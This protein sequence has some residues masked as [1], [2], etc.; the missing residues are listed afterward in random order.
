MVLLIA[1]AACGNA[2]A[3]ETAAACPPLREFADAFDRAQVEQDRPALEW[4]VSD[5]L[6]YI[7]GTGNR[8]GKRDFI[9]GW[10]SP[11]DD[12]EMPTLEDR[13]VLEL[14]P[15]A[16]IANARALLKGTSGGVPFQSEIRF[17]DAFR[18][19]SGCWRAIHIQVTRIAPKP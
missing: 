6:V 5:A 19:E 2:I 4:M 3:A 8:H 13:V 11:G 7:D 17:A 14:G 10:M 18:K 16:G 1:S 12:F 15:E 9:E